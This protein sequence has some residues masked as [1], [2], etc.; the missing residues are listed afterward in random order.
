MKLKSI[1]EH[2]ENATKKIPE[3]ANC[4]IIFRHSIRGKI[5]SGVGRKVKLTDEGVELARFFGRNLETEIG[6]VASS[7]CDRNI[8]T[9]EEILL[10]AKCKR[11]IIIAPNEL[12]GPQTKDKGLSDKVFEQYNFANNEIIYQMK[13][14]CLPGFNSVEDATKIMVDFMF[15]NGNKENSVD[16]FCT[17]DF[18]MAILYAGLF[19]FAETKD[20]II[21]NKWP[22][23]L[24][25]MIFWGNRN[26]FWS[27]WRG[28][29][30]EYNDF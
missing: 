11:E 13:K 15:A 17:H 30:K 19:N 26:H 10:G 12:E 8:Q 16:L 18:Q 6:F 24:E 9:C 23:M 5:D 1:Y 3:N 28:E 21:N 29:V 20:S 22:M 2:M 27:A 25:G 4:K 7:S 14:D